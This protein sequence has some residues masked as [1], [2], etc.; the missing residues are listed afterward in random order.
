MGRRY[1]TALL[2][3]ALALSV[4]Y[5][6]VTTTYYQQRQCD[7]YVSCSYSYGTLS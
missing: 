2:L 4:G 3:G 5:N 7:K 6:W 1:T